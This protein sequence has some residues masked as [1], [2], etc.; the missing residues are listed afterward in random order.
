MLTLVPETIENYARHQTVKETEVMIQLREATYAQTELPQMLS[1]PLVGQTLRTLCRLSGPGLAVEVGTFT[2]Y[3]S[4]W[5]AGGLHAEGRLLTMDINAASAAIAQQY[6][7]QDPLGAKIECKLGP[8][9]DTLD[10]IDEPIHFA[11]IDADKAGYIDYYERIIARMPSGGVLVAD[12]VLWSGRVLEPSEP[13][14]HALKNFGEHVAHDD[15]VDQ[16]ML[17]VRDGLLV[18]LKI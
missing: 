14:D 16:V 18:C 5:I 13:S 17:T 11:F 8:A 7:D 3:A 9:R 2:G 12:N 6:W 1:G 4:L 15:R 10:Q